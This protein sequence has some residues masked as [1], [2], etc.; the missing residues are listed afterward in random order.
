[1]NH[2]FKKQQKQSPHTH[3]RE[4]SFSRP[5]VVNSVFHVVGRNVLDIINQSLFSG[6]VA[7]FLKHA[8][9]KMYLKKPNLDLYASI[10][11]EN[12]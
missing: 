3:T 4:A 10:Y 2:V 7:S 8:V 12:S 6:V 9:V 11:S 1:M 5:W